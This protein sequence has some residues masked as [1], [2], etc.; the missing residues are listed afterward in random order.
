MFFFE[1]KSGACVRFTGRAFGRL[2]W[3]NGRMAQ[4]SCLGCWFHSHVC[5]WGAGCVGLYMDCCLM[6]ISRGGG[7][8]NSES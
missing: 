4:V 8:A 6:L 2:D 5:A 7:P 1:Q 3:V